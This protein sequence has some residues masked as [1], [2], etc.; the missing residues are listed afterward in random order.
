MSKGNT[1]MSKG[2]KPLMNDP[3]CSHV[4]DV[5]AAVTGPESES[6]DDAVSEVK[7]PA[8][9]I[10]KACHCN[11]DC[12]GSYFVTSV[13]CHAICSRDGGIA[14]VRKFYFSFTCTNLI[15]R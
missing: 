3:H 13:T 12:D 15:G 8:G 6:R 4:G 7:C 5:I 1:P 10:G 2:N 14:R 11:G 9:Y